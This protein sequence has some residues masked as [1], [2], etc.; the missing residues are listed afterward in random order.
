MSP[1]VGASLADNFWHS[2]AFRRLTGLGGC[3]ICSRPLLA[4]SGHPDPFNQCP[5]LGVKRTFVQVASMSAFDPKQTYE[6][7]PRTHVRPTSGVLV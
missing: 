5:L 7:A 4:Q 1:G 6:L 2:V 3:S